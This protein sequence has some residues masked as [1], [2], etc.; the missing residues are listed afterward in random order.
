MTNPKRGEY[1]LSLADQT[2]NCKLNMDVMMRIEQNL[3]GSLLK[4]AQQMSE[5]DISASQL[6]AILTPC[7]RSSG[8]DIKD[9]DVKK[10]VW[11]AGLT[12]A[13]GKVGEIIS[14]IV[15]GGE[16]GEMGNE[17]KVVNG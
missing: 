11:E 17:K 3:G 9:A 6:V 13:I 7:I 16:E 15:T 5:A 12:D 4:V 8:T 1:L 10:I 14:F 2:Y